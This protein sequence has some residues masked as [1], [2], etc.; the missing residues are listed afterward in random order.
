[1]ILSLAF[2]GDGIES[3]EKRSSS[4]SLSLSLERES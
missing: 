2:M 3:S 1:M 4:L